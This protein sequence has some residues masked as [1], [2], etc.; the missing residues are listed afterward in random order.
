MV[1]NSGKRVL[2]RQVLGLSDNDIDFE[3]LE[4]PVHRTCVPAIVDLM[5]EAKKNGFSMRLASGYRSFDHQLTI[6]NAKA[7]GVRPVLDDDENVLDVN[8]LS[9]K[10]LVFSILRWSALPGASR[11]HWGSDFDV[12]DSSEV[13]DSYDLK[14]TLSETILGGPF[15]AFHRWLD[16]YLLSNP[17]FYRP[18]R[19][20]LGGVSPEPWHLSYRPVAEK[21]ERVLTESLLAQTLSESDI[22][23]KDE[24]LNNLHEIYHR[25]II[26]VL[27]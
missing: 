23:L 8:K 19:E 14:L 10:Q 6:W 18:Y 26:R 13:G 11:H 2:S 3:Q 4:K 25:F 16:S 15:A 27:S 22:L 12:Y 1:N 9:K 21:C 5:A 24:V 7:K 17:T 20:D